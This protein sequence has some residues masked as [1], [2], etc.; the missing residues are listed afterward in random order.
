M[1]TQVTSRKAPTA[2]TVVSCADTAAI[3]TLT[4]FCATTPAAASTT[5]AADPT[6]ARL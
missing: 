2:A 4:C 3:T 6:D 1:T 5:A